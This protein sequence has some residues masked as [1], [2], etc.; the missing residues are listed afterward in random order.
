MIDAHP[1]LPPCVD[2]E[3]HGTFRDRPLAPHELSAALTPTNKLFVLAHLGLLR[4]APDKWRLDITGLVERPLCL[5]VPDLA[6]FAPA[7]VEAVHQC[8][9]NP[10][11]PTVA[12]RRVACVEWEG[13]WLRDVLA[14]AGTR[15][16][17]THV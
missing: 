12:T 6:R 9:G 7:R 11:T 17:A 10:L 14:A 15:P 4:L 16:E 1:D 13:V 2:Y 5:R 3:A 8:A